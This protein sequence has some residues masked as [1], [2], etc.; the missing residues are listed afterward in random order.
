M[1]ASVT[2]VRAWLI[3][4]ALFTLPL[5]AGIRAEAAT[6]TFDDL[7]PG[8]D[9]ALI[10]SGYAGLQWYYF[11]VLDGT[12][13]P[14]TEGYRTGIVS[15]NNVAF[16]SEG[17]M[18]MIWRMTNSFDL[19]SAYLTAVYEDG[20]QIRVEGYKGPMIRYET[21]S[22]GTTNVRL[23]TGITLTYENTYTLNVSG[24][25]LLHFDYAGVSQVRFITTSG[26]PFAMDN[27]EVTVPPTPAIH[28]PVEVGPVRVPTI[29]HSFKLDPR[30]IGND[31]RRNAVSDYLV[32]QDQ[33]SGGGG[34]LGSA[35][36]NW[37]TKDQFV[38]TVS[39][40]PGMKFL[41]KP[42]PGAEELSFNGFLW[43]E[44]EQAG[45]SEP[46]TVAVSFGGLEGT[47]PDFAPSISALSDSH[48]FFGFYR[49][50][51]GVF[52]NE[53]AFTSMTL[54]GTVAPQHTGLG[55]RD[56][57]P[58]RESQL[59]V[60]YTTQETNDPGSFVFIVPQTPPPKIAVWD[61]WAGTGIGLFVQGQAGRTVVV[62]SSADLIHWTS[63]STNVMPFTVC[64]ICPFVIVRD[65]ADRNTMRR[66]YRAFEVP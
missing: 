4:S 22:A 20:L 39:A 54:T 61:M 3:L 11:S 17:N 27:V 50:R 16:N 29:G 34:V 57:V 46:G 2:R 48:G 51:S 56:F 18:S 23:S 38:L 41:V 7:S 8:P 14:A 13:R 37:D 47:P 12:T 52:T 65:E 36:V 30:P 21:N 63:I 58:H 26:T 60:T 33:S 6:I 53:F 25:T 19:H 59:S 43:W 55:T 24:P 62:E 1:K 10:P 42:P 64:P 40:P 31:I 45:V 49:A 9:W 32:D 28:V 5:L 35:S 66:F 15:S 44:S